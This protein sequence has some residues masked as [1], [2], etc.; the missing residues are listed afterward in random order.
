MSDKETRKTIN[1]CM[2]HILN[3]FVED[4][5]Q[6][7]CIK[8]LYGTPS[9]FSITFVGRI[10]YEPVKRVSIIENEEKRTFI[11]QVDLVSAKGY[12]DD[13]VPE[14]TLSYTYI[15]E[16]TEDPK[17]DKVLYECDRRCSACHDKLLCYYTT[18]ITHA[19]NFEYE[20]GGWVER[21]GYPEVEV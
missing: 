14:I 20:N 6:V 17:N 11:F 15:G 19:K 7:I 3:T 18:D 8:P 10:N 4:D 21:H 16:I 2:L 13:T 9:G 1:K 12:T 5:C